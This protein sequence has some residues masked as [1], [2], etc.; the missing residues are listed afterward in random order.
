VSA[1]PRKCRRC[2]QAGHFAKTCGRE[3]PPEEP[4][5]A[6]RRSARAWK[7]LAMIYRGRWKAWED[8]AKHWRSIAREGKP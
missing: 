5:H 4:V 3:M 6:W 1:G 8:E 2:G 7:A